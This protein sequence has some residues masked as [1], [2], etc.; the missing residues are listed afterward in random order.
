MNSK[1][2]FLKEEGLLNLNAKKVVHP[3]FK[4][5]D[6]FDPSDLAQV[7]YELLRAT[8]QE[9]ISVAKTCRLFGFSREYFYRLSHS[10]METG[11]PALL[12]SPQAGRR[13]LIALNQN[14]LTFIIYRKIDEPQLSGEQLRKEIF[15]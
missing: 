9:K 13:P 7:R 10:F 14:I 8:K 12:K 15:Q 6:F 4:S 3:L 2:D 11:F 1:N 5:V